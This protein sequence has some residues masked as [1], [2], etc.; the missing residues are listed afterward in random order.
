MVCVPLDGA[1]A[2]A[3]EHSRNDER[4]LAV[5]VPSRRA[6]TFLTFQIGGSRIAVQRTLVTAFV[7][8]TSGG[9]P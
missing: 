8:N 1:R 6:K 7:C 9:D 2:G 5:V 4:T 3:Q